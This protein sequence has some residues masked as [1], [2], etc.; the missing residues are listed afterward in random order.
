MI[1]TRRVEPVAGAR[2]LDPATRKPLP[3]EGATVPMKQYWLRRLLKGDVQ[4]VKKR[5]ARRREE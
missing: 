3:A 1:E 4:L 5:A 2:V